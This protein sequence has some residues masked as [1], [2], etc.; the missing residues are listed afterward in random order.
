MAEL[1]VD[2]LEQMLNVNNPQPLVMDI[3]DYGIVVC[4]PLGLV[5]NIK[6]IVRYVAR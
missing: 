4:R 1:I 5:K 3:L 2:Q 6:I